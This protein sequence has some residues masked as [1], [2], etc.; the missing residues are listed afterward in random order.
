MVDR[1][2]SEIYRVVKK[3]THMLEPI[4][5]GEKTAWQKKMLADLRNSIGKEAINLNV[6]GLLFENIDPVYQSNYGKLNNLE[7]AI[8]ITLQIFGLF[9]QGKTY[10]RT[11]DQENKRYGYKNLG[12][13]LSQIKD[14]DNQDALGN[15]FNILI[16]SRNN[17]KFCYHLLQMVKL[18]KNYKKPVEVN[19]NCLSAD[20]YTFLKGQH[21]QVR[22]A[23]SRQYFRGHM[24]K[25][26]GEKNE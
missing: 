8:L 26:E 20:I 25:E 13:S 7:T 15:R 2:Y 14:E 17:E 23:W 9:N 1:N 19:Y 22:V 5:E 3:V 10:I 6:L 11:V 12:Y 24:T 21:N 4:G 16:T 18:M